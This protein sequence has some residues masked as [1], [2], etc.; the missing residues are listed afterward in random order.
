MYTLVPHHPPSLCTPTRCNLPGK[1]GGHLLV[2]NLR[3]KL[4]GLPL[5]LR[6]QLSRLLKVPRRSRRHTRRF[7]SGKRMH[8]QRPPNACVVDSLPRSLG[9]SSPIISPSREIHVLCRY[10]WRVMLS[11]RMPSSVVWTAGVHGTL[12]ELF[13][14]SDFYF[15]VP[16]A[17]LTPGFPRVRWVSSMHYPMIH[18]ITCR[19]EPDHRARESGAAS[20]TWCM[21]FLPWERT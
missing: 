8:R 4:G 19:S 17:A 1:L 3:H 15:T 2:L 11:P 12:L 9:Y 16:I 21:H 7:C 6:G 13:T 10:M 5:D 18:R 14:R 20:Q